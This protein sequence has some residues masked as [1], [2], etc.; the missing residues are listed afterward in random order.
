MLYIFYVIW[1]SIINIFPESDM[2]DNMKQ[3]KLTRA[4]ELIQKLVAISKIKAGGRWSTY[5]ESAQDPGLVTSLYRTVCASGENK[6]TNL[7]DIVATV[8]STISLINEL[9]SSCY[10][11]QE[12]ARE[13]YLSL[14][15]AQHGIANL[16]ITYYDCEKTIKIIDKLIGII[17]RELSNQEIYNAKKDKYIRTNMAHL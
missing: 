3:Y 14:Y 17:N 8:H 12:S 2:M 1:F 13:L 6:I 11:S 7:K 5:F 16:K 9:D 4:H 10:R 15:M